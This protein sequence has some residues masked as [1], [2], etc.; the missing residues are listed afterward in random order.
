MFVSIFFF[1]KIWNF[2]DHFYYLQPVPLTFLRL[3]LLGV[4][5]LSVFVLPDQKKE[6][7][8]FA[9]YL[10]H[11][12]KHL[13]FVIYLK[14]VSLLFSEKLSGQGHPWD[15]P[16]LQT[17]GSLRNRSY[18]LLFEAARMETEPASTCGELQRAS[19]IQKGQLPPDSTDWLLSGRPSIS[20]YFTVQEKIKFRLCEI[21]WFLNVISPLEK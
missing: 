18:K 2:I 16:E 7:K 1:T 15:F 20:I 13:I 17:Y 21:P 11:S 3:I 12:N 8:T 4:S 6:K 5:G 9:I 14:R 19:P 10:Q